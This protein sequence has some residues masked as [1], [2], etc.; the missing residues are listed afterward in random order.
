MQTNTQ[1]TLNSI[2]EA[3]LTSSLED[4]LVDSLIELIDAIKEDPS[5]EAVRAISIIS[6]YLAEEFK[7]Q[8][9]L[10]TLSSIAKSEEVDI[11]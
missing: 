1:V 10:D 9:V 4:D 7:Q 6:R 11:F 5:S 2:R 3:I 8:S